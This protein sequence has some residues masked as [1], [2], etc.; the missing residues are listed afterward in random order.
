MLH[1]AYNW[2]RHN[3]T[4]VYC[5]FCGWRRRNAATNARHALRVVCARVSCCAVAFCWRALYVATV[6]GCNMRASRCWPAAAILANR[7]LSLSVLL[8][9]FFFFFFH[10]VA[11]GAGEQMA[12]MGIIIRQKMASAGGVN[13][14]NEIIS[15]NWQTK[16]W[17]T[18]AASV[19]SG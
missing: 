17:Q 10:R 9:F 16:V 2:W 8:F 15:V 4:T 14:R 12:I 11:A 1:Y 18:S 5:G 3:I 13:R 6:A 7:Q 19:G